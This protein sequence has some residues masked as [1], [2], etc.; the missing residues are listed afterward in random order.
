MVRGASILK[1]E[2]LKRSKLWVITGLPGRLHWCGPYENRSDA[3]S[4]KQGL[5]RF[6]KDN[7]VAKE[8]RSRK[9]YLQELILQTREALSHLTSEN[10]DW[11]KMRMEFILYYTERQE[12]LPES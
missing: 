12:D 8:K 5:A 6:L 2:Q 7:P 11:F 1:I 3:L 9:N 4:D 10:V